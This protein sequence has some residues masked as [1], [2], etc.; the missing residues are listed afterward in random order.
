VLRVYTRHYPPCTRTESGYRRCHC[1]KWINGTLPTGKF[2]RMSANSRSWEG[3]ERKARLLEVNADPLRQEPP[4]KSIRITIEEAIRDFLADEQARQLAKTTTCQ[5]KSL[6]QQQLLPWAKSQAL[7]FLDQLTTPKLREFRASWKN[8]ALTSQRKHHRLNSFFD[9]C[10]ENEWV[11][12]N[13]ARRMKAVHVTP[14]PTDY[15]TASE[16]AR[17]LDGTY[18]YAAWKGG[19]DF[20]HRSLRLRALILLM[21]WSG[22]SILDAVTLERHRLQGHRLL[23]YRHKT[24]VPVFVPI[25]SA[26]A[27]MMH[28]LPNS[29][30]RYFFWSGNGD[31][32]T[33]KK[34][35]QRSLRRLFKAV[36]LRTE[37]DQPKRS[38][39][40]MFRDT[41]AV[42]LLLAGVP[43]DQVSLLLAHSSVKI[44]EKHYAPFVKA[45]QLQLENS[46]RLAWQS[47]G[48]AEAILD[49][50][51]RV[52]LR[53]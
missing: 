11:I 40:H 17:I 21:R 36:N 7:V 38:H 4:D 50:E 32:H 35:W 10:I 49:G 28:A 31:P 52:A 14:V 47:M 8:S 29:N 30:P 23:L 3:A 37:D 44:T 2:I 6:F 16:F 12:R 26:V 42:E 1:P 46:V 39:P 15:F 25:P 13:P 53:N 5:S 45:R 18:A 51:I 27:E 9:F 33:A 24:K 43:L 34:G 20:E 22:L 41:F 19:R 48:N